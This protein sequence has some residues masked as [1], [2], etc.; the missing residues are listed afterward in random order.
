MSK[1]RKSRKE[2]IRTAERR[3]ENGAVSKEEVPESRAARKYRRIRVLLRGDSHSGR[4]HGDSGKH[5]EKHGSAVHCGRSA[6]A[7]GNDHQL[8]QKVHTAGIF[9]GDRFRAVF[10]DGS[11]S[12][13]GHS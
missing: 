11:Q 10:V 5:T 8:L 4:P 13:C 7:C 3:A 12:S 6:D 9:Y 1:K 2:K